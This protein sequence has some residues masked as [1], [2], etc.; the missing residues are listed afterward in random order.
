MGGNGDNAA[1]QRQFTHSYT[2]AAHYKPPLIS[3]VFNL[4]YY[5]MSCH[6]P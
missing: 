1:V 2:F 4:S 3:T 5:S 6:D